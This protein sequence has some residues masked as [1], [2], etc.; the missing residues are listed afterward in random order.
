MQQ[1]QTKD[2]PRSLEVSTEPKWPG[3]APKPD[4]R[5]APGAVKQKPASSS[6]K[7]S[8]SS[9]KPGGKSGAGIKGDGK[10]AQAAAEWHY[11]EV[12][13]SERFD[14]P[15][16]SVE[17]VERDIVETLAKEQSDG[18]HPSLELTLVRGRACRS[19]IDTHPKQSIL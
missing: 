12:K 2:T 7:A 1:L 15:E 10:A 19:L 4:T 16:P 5:G 8:S 3:M 14:V 17:D 11:D 13:Y 18:A 6:S 9:S